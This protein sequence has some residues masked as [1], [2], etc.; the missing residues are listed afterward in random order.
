MSSLTADPPAQPRCFPTTTARS[1]TAASGNQLCGCYLGT[2]KTV[3]AICGLVTAG[4]TGSLHASL[5]GV[6]S[7]SRA[8]NG[9]E[10]TAAD[11]T[12]AGTGL[13]TVNVTPYTET[14]GTMYAAVI[15]DLAAATDWSLATSVTTGVTSGL[16]FAYTVSVISALPCIF[17]LYDDGTVPPWVMG[18]SALA[19]DATWNSGT[20]P[21]HKGF[22]I[23]TPCDKRLIGFDFEMRTS[24]DNL[25]TFD[26]NLFNGSN[27]ALQTVHFDPAKFWV[28]AGSTLRG[29]VPIQPTTVSSG[30]RGALKPTSTTNPQFWVKYS[31]ASA[32]LKKNV[33]GL[34]WSTSSNDGV[35]WTDSETDN[36]FNIVPVFDQAALGGAGARINIGG[37][38]QS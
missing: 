3:A 9:S 7:T 4:T 15:D 31:F 17:P 30:Y 13:F 2:G 35:T 19:S 23:V 5:Q 16:P 14:K 38:V 1:V 21:L 24:A 27:S 20:T 37:S 8:P 32:A 11:A 6:A 18:L 26:F 10:L 22:K 25:F 29:F 33:H 34:C 36:F 12:P 28:S